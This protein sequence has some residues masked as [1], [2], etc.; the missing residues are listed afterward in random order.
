[1]PPDWKTDPAIPE[2]IRQSLD[3]FCS[4]LTQ[5]LGDQLVVIVLYGR[6]AKGESPHG[7]SEDT[8]LLGLRSAHHATLD[9]LLPALEQARTGIPLTLLTLTEADL[10]T[11]S[12]VFPIKFTDIQRQHR[13]LAG[14][15]PFAQLEIT[16]DRLRRQCAREL[17]NLLLR[18]RSFY[19]QRGQHPEQLEDNLTHSISSFLST[20]AALIELKSGE[21]PASK[22]ATVATASQLGLNAQ[23]LR[24][25]LALKRGELKPD[26]PALK[27]L[28]A[29]FLETIDQAARLTAKL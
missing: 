12:E 29:A 13:L 17:Q 24:D 28:F 26:S 25:L 4:R 2:T 27:G 10:P 7:N 8:V 15:E 18:L 11:F 14:R 22:S 5:D 1:M 19:L 3:R 20:L 23:L 16:R 21:R 6:I 9:A